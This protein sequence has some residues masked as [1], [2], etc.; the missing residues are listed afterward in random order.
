MDEYLEG[1][2][3]GY[4]TGVNEI[5]DKII[6]DI[7]ILNEKLLNKLIEGND[8]YDKMLNDYYHELYD[9]FKNVRNIY[10]KYIN[11]I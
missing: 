11:N 1:Y 2:Y 3:R 6:S 5:L 9:V 7:D 10:D 4:S 8:G